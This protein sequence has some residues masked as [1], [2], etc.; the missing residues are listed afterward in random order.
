M[1]GIV[2]RKPTPAEYIEPGSMLHTHVHPETD[3]YISP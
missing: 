1:A 3:S 2:K